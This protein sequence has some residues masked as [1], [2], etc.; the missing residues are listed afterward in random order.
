MIPELDDEEAAVDADG[1]GH[2]AG[3]ERVELGRDLVGQLGLE[4]P[5]RRAA[6][7]RCAALREALCERG[8]IGPA[9]DLLR[10]AL[11]VAAHGRLFARPL[12]AEK[13][14][15]QAVFGHAL[16]RAH[17]GELGLD[18]VVADGECAPLLAVEELRPC[19][20]RAQL[21]AHGRGVDTS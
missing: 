8:D 11:G 13:D 7:Y 15:G 5:A 12:D 2:R 6:A 9:A 10:Q 17:A 4:H 1:L 16:S 19:D 21:R 14:L 3:L 20:L 18:L